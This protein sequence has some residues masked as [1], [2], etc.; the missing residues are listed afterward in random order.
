MNEYTPR[1]RQKYVDDVVTVLMDKFKYV[2]PL[3]VPKLQKISINI[4][5]GNAKED[6]NALKNAQAELETITGQKPVVTKARNSISNFKIREGDPVGVKV[7]LRGKRMWEFLDRLTSMAL[8][9]VRDF[10]GV[11]DRAFDGRGNYTLGVKEQIIF[12]EID[13]DKIDK[14]RGMDINITTSAE[15]DE[16]ALELLKHLGM[17][18][19]KR[20]G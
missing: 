4:G 3:Q 19:R 6:P 1:M 7:T 16:E 8:P 11:S 13:Y 14:V 2:N 5:L 17:P 15:T 10:N 9:R 20:Q 18:F 12:P